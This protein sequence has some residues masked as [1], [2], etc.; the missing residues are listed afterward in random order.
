ME[1]KNSYAII[2]LHQ[3]DKSFYEYTQ[4]FNSSYSCWKDDISIKAAVYMYIGGLKVGASRADIMPNWQKS[5][6]DS[7]IPLQKEAAK[8]SLYRPTAIITSRLGYSSTT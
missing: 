4:E 3:F 7:L 8:H 2:K 5:K 1:G 6:Y